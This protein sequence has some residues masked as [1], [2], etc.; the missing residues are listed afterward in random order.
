VPAPDSN[1]PQPRQGAKSGRVA[2]AARA[3]WGAA[4]PPAHLLP[5]VICNE[6][7]AHLR[8]E[9]GADP[10]M[11]DKTIMRVIKKV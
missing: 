6:I 1:R 2:R 8:T 9:E 3:I 11:T 5:K 10:D 4:G 7:R